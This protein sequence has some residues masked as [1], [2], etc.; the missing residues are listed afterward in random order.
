MSETFKDPLLLAPV[1]LV[2]PNG[3]RYPYGA[4]AAT[5]AARGTAL[6]SAISSAA[7]NDGIICAGGSYQGRVTL[8]D[9]VDI[10]FVGPATIYD[11]T[12]TTGQGVVGDGGSAV[13]C[14][15]LGYPSITSSASSGSSDAACLLINS[16]DSNIH[17]QLNSV[18]RTSSVDQPAVYIKGKLSGHIRRAYSQTYDALIV[19][20]DSE[21]NE[22]IVDLLVDELESDEHTGVEFV[23]WVKDSTLRVGRITAII[24]MEVS[25]ALRNN[26]ITIGYIS[27]QTTPAD[28]FHDDVENLPENMLIE[29]GTWDAN[30]GVAANGIPEGFIIRNTR[31]VNC[32][33]AIAITGSDFRDGGRIEDV[34][35]A[36]SGSASISGTGDVTLK[37]F[38]ANKP[39]ASTVVATYDKPQTVTVLISPADSA[40]STGD[41]KAIY[42]IPPE[43]YGHNIVGVKAFAG[44]A[45]TT[46]SCTIQIARDRAGSVVDVLSTAITIETGERSSED[47]TTQPVINTSNDDLAAGD[48]LRFDIDAVSAT[49]QR[50]LQ[51]EI[52]TALP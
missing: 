46:N 33:A 42:R 7:A 30:T 52:R 28:L 44:T 25:G 43:M 40:A 11:N 12:I 24:P 49:P 48:F 13:S 5:D 36:C 29:V 31:F 1:W 37:S 17:V 35:A 45:G 6:T 8:K 32:S 41:G 51:V 23:S 20:G 2:K 16:P 4:G 39:L 14:K 50:G 18:E 22:A 10:T 21:G 9:G 19:E 15:I 47:A 27:G 34:T 38:S 3:L 26:R